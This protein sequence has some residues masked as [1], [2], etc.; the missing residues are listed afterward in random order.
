MAWP[1]RRAKEGGKRVA[2]LKDF[3][4]SGNIL[5]L[6]QG[7]E[8]LGNDVLAPLGTAVSPSL[9]VRGMNVAGRA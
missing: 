8:G 7:I 3:L 1:G 5:Q 2:P 9:L 6:F 4:I